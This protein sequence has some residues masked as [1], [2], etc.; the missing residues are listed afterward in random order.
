VPLSTSVCKKLVLRARHSL[1]L[2]A[3]PWPPS[4]VK[5]AA[6]FK[7]PP[8]FVRRESL[9][10]KHVFSKEHS[11]TSGKNQET[12]NVLSLHYDVETKRLLFR[13]LGVHGSNLGRQTIPHT[14]RSIK[15]DSLIHKVK[16]IKNLPSG[17]PAENHIWYWSAS[18]RSVK[19]F[20]SI[21][22]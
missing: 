19:T 14:W 12:I 9:N 11:H 18:R 20:G 8:S 7:A 17:L 4:P 2:P 22:Q 1:S 15:P 6:A 16:A 3:S 13:I 21:C 10:L 5:Q